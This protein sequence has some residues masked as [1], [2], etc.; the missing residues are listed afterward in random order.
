MS[1]SAEIKK[2][3]ELRTLW[4]L[5]G[6][7]NTLVRTVRCCMWPAG[8][9]A[10]VFLEFKDGGWELLVP[11]T[12]SNNIPDTDAALTDWLAIHKPE[13]KRR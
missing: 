6:P 11:A 7:E 4:E 9:C 13:Q 1:S 12:A 5:P 2:K 3:H 10:V 8:G